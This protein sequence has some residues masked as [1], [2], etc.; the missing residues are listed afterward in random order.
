LRYELKDLRLFQ[1]IVEAGN[2]SVGA[3]AMHMTA[4]SASYRLKNLE[5]AVGSPLFLRTPKG[6]RPTPAG[7]V[8]GRHAKRLLADVETMHA[9]L[10][11]YS[12]NLRGSIRLLANSSSLNS[13][14]I[15][16]LARFLASNANINVDLK[17]KESPTISQA[18]EEGQ[19]DI[20][21]GAGLE[22][23]P[24]LRRELYAVDRL[25]CVVAPDHP[26]AGA[27]SVAFHD[28]LA[29]DL[30]SMDR[31]SSNFLYLSNQARLAGMPMRVRVHVHN[32]SSVI[33]MVRAGVGAAIVPAST[34]QTALLQDVVVALEITD[35]WAAREL[36]LVYA[37]GPDQPP[38]IREFADILLN[39]PQVA[40]ARE[41]H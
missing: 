17:E 34:A 22:E 12:S 9:E 21:V 18:I 25:V 31:G 4:S 13:F 39:D 26:L 28:L 38:L 40:V 6:M 41:K 7:E 5:Y 37:C 20:G 1:A 19:A 14:I 36:Y 24:G 8:L 15:P 23:R 16:S 27:T 10:S 3:A 2:L 11:D 32:F 29:Y 33:Y 30:V 35:S